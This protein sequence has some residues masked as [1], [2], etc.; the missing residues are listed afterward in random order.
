MHLGHRRKGENER[1]CDK[2][3]AERGG[4]RAS[5]GEQVSERAHRSEKSGTAAVPTHGARQRVN[6]SPPFFFFFS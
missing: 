3:Q 4:K 1:I 6:S 5:K 2:R